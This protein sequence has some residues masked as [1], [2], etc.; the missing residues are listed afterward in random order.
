MAAELNVGKFYERLGKIHAHF[1]KHRAT[2]WGGAAVVSLQRG[3]H[4]EEENQPYLKSIILHQYLF[5]YELPDTLVVLTQEG[6][7]TILATKKKCEFLEPAVGKAPVGS[8]IV[9]LNLIQRSKGD[10][11]DDHLSALTTQANI[12]KGDKIGVILKEVSYKK[13]AAEDEKKEEEKDNGNKK[14]KTDTCH[15]WETHL[16][17]LE[18]KAEFVDVSGGLSLVMAQ[19]DH[20]ELDLLKK[21]SVLTNKVLK[22][23]FISRLEEVIDSNFA[24]GHEALAQ[25]MDGII[26]D[27]SKIKLKVPTSDVESCYFPIV[28]S[29]GKYDIRVSAQVRGWDV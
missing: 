5:G 12:K 28:Q 24:I 9:E 15:N 26:E 4:D 11:V 29:G 20:D 17:G 13:S 2:A 19:K 10:N 3:P 25:E 14:K 6:M 23:G 21:S 8:P 1:L 7:C 16:S 27:P 18:L 22:H